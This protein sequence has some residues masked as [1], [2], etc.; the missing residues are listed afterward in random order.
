MLKSASLGKKWYKK[1]YINPQS[2]F[3]LLFS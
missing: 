3:C 1:Y 2:M